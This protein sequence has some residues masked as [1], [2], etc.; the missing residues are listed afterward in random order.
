MPTA[1]RCDIPGRPWQEVVLDTR[2]LQGSD[3]H[4]EYH[5]VLMC[6]DVFTKWI[7]VILLRRHDAKSVAAA[8]TG[9]CQL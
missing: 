3:G 9:V 5:C 7:E 1:T 8:F 4:A 6:V 2:E